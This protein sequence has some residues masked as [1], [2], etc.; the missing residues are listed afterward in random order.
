MLNHNLYY[1]TNPFT[2]PKIQF[3]DRT[4][5]WNDQP[6]LFERNGIGEE[7]PL[8]ETDYSLDYLSPAKNRGTSEVSTDVTN[9]KFGNPRPYWS[10]DYDIG[11]FEIEDTQLKFGVEGDVNEET[12]TFSLTSFG[13]YW[14]KSGSSWEI[15]SDPALQET[16]YE[17]EGNSPADTNTWFGFE[18]NWLLRP[19]SPLLHPKIGAGFYKLSVFE[20]SVEKN[21]FYLDLRDAV[22]QY[23]PNIYLKY[24]IV[25]QQEHYLQYLDINK[26]WQ[27]IS[28]G[29]IFRIWDIRNGNYNVYDLYTY[30]ENALVQVNGIGQHP[31]LIWGPANSELFEIQTRY[32]NS[33]WQY[34][35]FSSILEYT[36][37]NIVI[38]SPNTTHQNLYYRVRKDQTEEYTNEV[39]VLK[40]RIEKEL[41]ENKV[42]N[43]SLFQNYPNPFNPSTVISFTLPEKQYVK[44]KIY[45]I[46]GREVKILADSKYE[47]GI[48]NVEFNGSELS[49]GVYFYRIIAGNNIETKKLQILK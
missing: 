32:D 13:T 44:L 19:Q 29:N 9:D 40:P 10:R 3:D 7:D 31:R 38:T 42:L 22:T 39:H 16:F 35:D 17:I 11:A 20:N 33:I 49:S 47:A 21:Y 12:Y 27:N 2:I 24:I 48:S 23:S 30:W 36:D 28:N 14:E 18:Y 25:S 26:V 8:L 45:D 15:S 46:N 37:L 5:N 6:D 34:R 4:L 41:P 1:I 43:F